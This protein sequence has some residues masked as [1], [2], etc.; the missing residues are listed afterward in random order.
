MD[1]SVFPDSVLRKCC[2]PVEY[3]DSALNDLLAE[4][5]KFMK[6]HRGIG[7]AAPQIGISKRLFVCEIEKQSFIAINPGIK[8]E[9]EEVEMTEGC[10]SLPGLEISIPRH[11]RIHLKCQDADGQSRSFML[12][13]LWARVAQHEMDHLNGILICDYDTHDATKT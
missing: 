12:T 8:Q 7:L 10:L 2:E 3:F 11:R 4:M 1:L 9:D 13:D 6:H 5:L